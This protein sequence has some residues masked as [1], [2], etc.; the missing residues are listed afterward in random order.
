MK[1]SLH[2]ENPEIAFKDEEA[3]STVHLHSYGIFCTCIF[4]KLSVAHLFEGAV[5]F[6]SGKIA[7]QVSSQLK[8]K[9]FV[10]HFLFRAVFPLY[11]W[12]Y[13]VIR[14]FSTIPIDEHANEQ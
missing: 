4:G 10:E 6:S 12:Y 1:L 8:T 2:E 14:A 9:V 7:K 5:L 3:Y 11:E 13:A